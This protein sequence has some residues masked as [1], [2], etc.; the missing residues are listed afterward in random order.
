M[1][2]DVFIF[3]KNHIDFK[4]YPV[5]Y[6]AVLTA[7]LVLPC[8]KYLPVQFGYEN[9]LLEN[10]QLIVL[11][12]S[13]LIALLAKTNKKFFIF[14]ALIITILMLREI[15]CGRTIFFPVPG[16]EN[17]FYGWKDIKYGWL[18]EPIYGT[19]IACTG[20]YFIFNKLYLNLFKIIKTV[21][22][23]IWNI[24]LMLTGMTVGMYSEKA[25]HNMVLEEM[26]ELLFYVSLMGIVWLYSRNKSFDAENT[27]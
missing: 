26:A 16:Y 4:F 12:M 2:K 9:G 27:N 22:F 18:A 25:L 23:P 24:L 13:F 10:L 14:A 17:A 5:T 11:F 3:I 15:N 7:I 1:M 6:I 20:L 8:A 19:Y 21:K